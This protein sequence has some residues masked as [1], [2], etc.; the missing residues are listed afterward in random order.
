[1]SYNHLPNQLQVHQHGGVKSKGKK[2][3]DF[4]RFDT[5]SDQGQNNEDRETP[6]TPPKDPPPTT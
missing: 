2:I 3:A 1:T 4:N 5:I 6:I